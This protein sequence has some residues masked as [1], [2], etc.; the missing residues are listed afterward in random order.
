MRYANQN[1]QGIFSV[2]DPYLGNW[3]NEQNT[4]LISMEMDDVYAIKRTNRSSGKEYSYSG[5][6]DDVSIVVIGADDMEANIKEGIFDTI[7]THYLGKDFAT[8]RRAK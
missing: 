6:K 5:F 3:E 4:L 8:Y 1:Q 2:S 7:K